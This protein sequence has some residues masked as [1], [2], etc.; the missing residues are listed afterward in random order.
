MHLS[1]I[2]GTLSVDTDWSDKTL[3]VSCEQHTQTHN[4]LTAF[5]RDNP[6][7]QYQKKHSPTHT[8]PDHRTSFINFL[9]LQRSMASSLFILHAWQSSRTTSVQAMFGLPLGLG[10]WTSYSILFFTQSS[11]SHTTHRQ[12][13]AKI[14]ILGCSLSSLVRSRRPSRENRFSLS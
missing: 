2:S 12:T 11:S 5:V 14:A 3:P 7:R 6:G 10:P 4:H 13:A 1:T 9:H 8:Q